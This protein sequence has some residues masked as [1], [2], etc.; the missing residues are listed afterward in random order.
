METP[1][2][3]R[4]AVLKLREAAAQGATHV[5][6]ACPYCISMFEDARTALGLDITVAD[7]TEIVAG[8]LE[9]PVG[10]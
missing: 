10:K 1:V 4:F 5:V 2:E 3:E 9:E 7:V 6:T 8:A